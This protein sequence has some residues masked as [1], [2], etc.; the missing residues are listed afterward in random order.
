[1][2]EQELKAFARQNA[3]ALAKPIAR[4]VEQVITKGIQGHLHHAAELQLRINELEAAIRRALESLCG[5]YPSMAADLSDALGE[6]PGEPS[7]KAAIDKAKPPLLT[8]S[9]ENHE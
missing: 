8:P 6:P 2:T 4:L 1:M 9:K 5:D 3:P 7:R